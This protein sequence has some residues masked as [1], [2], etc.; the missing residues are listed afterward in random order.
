MVAGAL[1]AKQAQDAAG[2]QQQ[3]AQGAAANQQAMAQRMS[4]EESFEPAAVEW[5]VDPKEQVMMDAMRQDQETARFDEI[6]KMLGLGAPTTQSMQ[7]PADAYTQQQ[8]M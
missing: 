7:P 5:N 6:I 8:M 1:M 2:Q 3:Q 4:I